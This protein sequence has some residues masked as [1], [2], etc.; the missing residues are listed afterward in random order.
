MTT[1]FPGRFAKLFTGPMWSGQSKEDV[2][3][4]Q[5]VNIYTVIILVPFQFVTER[6]RYSSLLCIILCI[7]YCM[8]KAGEL[9][10]LL[11]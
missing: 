7:S 2:G 8:G 11:F 1:E 4:T 3:Y 5:K 9:F 6:I 10:T